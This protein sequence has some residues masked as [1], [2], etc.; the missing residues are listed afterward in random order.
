MCDVNGLKIMNDNNGH[1]AGD[2]LLKDVAHSLADVFGND[3]VYRV[4]GDE[5]AV[6]DCTSDKETF[7]NKVT[8]ARNTIDRLGRSVSMGCIYNDS[9]EIDYEKIKIQVDALMYEEK[10]KYYEGRHDRRH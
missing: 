5:F 3:N 1:E 7:G 4:G 8:E 6:Y 2:E 9:G 10:R